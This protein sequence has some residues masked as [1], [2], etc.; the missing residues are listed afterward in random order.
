MY[1]LTVESYPSGLC[2][3]CKR[4]LY[5]CQAADNLKADFQPWVREVWASFR[6]EN[7]RVPRTSVE[8]EQ[9]SCPMCR[10]AHFSPIGKTGPKKIVNTPIIN[11]SN[12]PMECEVQPPILDSMCGSARR[13]CYICGQIT[14]QGIPHGCS[15]RDQHTTRQSR[16]DRARSL[17][18]PTKNRRKRNLSVL[19]GKEE[20]RA[21]EQIVSEALGRIE[22]RR[23]KKF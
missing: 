11:P 2:N 8:C 5:K 10:C 18:P 3:T 15:P 17:S 20:K 23:G 13:I 16:V 14:G 19:L 9:C 4:S 1:D 7:I 12:D 21:Q 22:E 6:I